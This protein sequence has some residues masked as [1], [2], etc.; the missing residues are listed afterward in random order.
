MTIE[1]RRIDFGG[2]LAIGYNFAPYISGEFNYSEGSF[3]I[4]GGPSEKLYAY[5]LDGVFKM[6]AGSV[7]DP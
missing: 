5:T 4:L 2:D 6:L 3:R 7:I 1:R